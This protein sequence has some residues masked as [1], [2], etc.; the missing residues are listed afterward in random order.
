MSADEGGDI[1]QE[2]Q[3]QTKTPR[4]KRVRRR[5]KEPASIA[6][7]GSEGNASA[8]EITISTITGVDQTA[9]ATA[10]VAV[11]DTTPPVVEAAPAA[12][13][14]DVDSTIQQWAQETVVPST[15][16]AT[17]NEFRVA[18]RRSAGGGGTKGTKV[19]REE[20]ALLIRSMMI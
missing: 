19:K 15:Q 20:V 13:E 14:A 4:F 18:A 17:S 10:P 5:R 3:E 11:E 6:T 9:A 1:Q 7:A 16:D 8:E 2:Q 12:D